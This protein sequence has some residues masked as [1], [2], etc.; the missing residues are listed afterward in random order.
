MVILTLT[1]FRS[2]SRENV[3]G[4]AGSSTLYG[5]SPPC[6]WRQLNLG[7]HA[8]NRSAAPAHSNTARPDAANGCLGAIFIDKAKMEAAAM[9]SDAERYGHPKSRLIPI[10]RFRPPLPGSG[11]H[12]AV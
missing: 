3:D 2:T 10:A 9:V 5:A 7:E 11:Q 6:T 8:A 4:F 1:P 12:R